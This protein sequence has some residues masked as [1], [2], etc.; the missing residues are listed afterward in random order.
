M[1]EITN[2]AGLDR[3]TISPALLEQMK[4][5][6]EPVTKTFYFQISKKLDVNKAK[7]LKLKKIIVDEKMF[8]WMMNEDAMSTEKL[9]EGIRKF[10]AGK[11]NKVIIR[12]DKV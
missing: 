5:S 1:G 9:A 10:A 7:K 2:L 8:R 12:Y 4:N 6:K 3:L 11:Y